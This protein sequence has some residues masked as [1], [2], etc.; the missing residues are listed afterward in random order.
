MNSEVSYLFDT[1]LTETHFE[2]EKER[3]ERIY[4]MWFNMKHKNAIQGPDSQTTPEQ[5]KLQE[6]I[7][8][9]IRNLRWK[10]DQELIK[11]SHHPLF[12]FNY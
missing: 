7:V 2:T 6:E 4:E 11:F 5:L 8:D 10:I 3:E 12:Q 1:D 9:R